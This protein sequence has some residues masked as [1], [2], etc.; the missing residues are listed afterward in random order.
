MP[1]VS[2]TQHF[3]R[4][5]TCE[6]GKGKIEYTDQKQ[7]GFFLEVLASGKKTFRQRYTDDHGQKRHYKIGPADVLTLDQ[8]RKE[9]KSIL[10]KVHMG[11]DP[12]ATRQEKRTVPRLAE[13]VATRYLPFAQETKRSWKTDE[14]MLRVHI[15]PALGSKPIDT[16]TP[17]HVASLAQR[18][19][20][21][22]YAG[23]TI[24]RAVILLRY[25]FNLARKWKISGAAE[26]PAAEQSLAPTQHRERFLSSDE[27]R[28]LLLSLRKDENQVAAR[29][30]LLLLLTGARRNEVTH[31]KWAFINWQQRTLRVPLSKSGKERFIS[32]NDGAIALLSSVE[33]QLDNPYV[34][35]SPI[36]GKPSPSLHFP[37][38]RIRDRAGLK[39]MRLH[40]LRHSF[41]SF[42]VNSGVP[43]YTV[44]GLLGHTQIR[45]T[46]RYAHL[47]D[48]TLSEAAQMAG[49]VIDAAVLPTFNLNQR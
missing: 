49:K 46:Q 48:E 33:P 2:L 35:P 3:V 23:G 45:T 4:T 15:L 8:A 27:L 18:M 16:I 19:K 34:F 1:R 10:A 43:L 20:A 31:A 22:D 44:Q 7:T 32:L 17:E 13:F 24:N 26:N 21:Q 37:W 38:V 25:I 11:Q 9:A 47:A 14:I 40:D 12:Q 41:A 5:A 28:A 30:I 36:T 6:P 29:A 39:D 42:L